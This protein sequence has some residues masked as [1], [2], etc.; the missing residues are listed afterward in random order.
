MDAA[1]T[2]AVA[3][4]LLGPLGAYI[5]AARRLSGKI[6]TSEASDLW[7]ESASIRRDYAQRLEIA[8]ERIEVLENQ[9][10]ALEQQVAGLQAQVRALEERVESP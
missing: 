7:A 5:V 10:A 8:N 6:G 1:T 2:V 9:K 4:A 3:I